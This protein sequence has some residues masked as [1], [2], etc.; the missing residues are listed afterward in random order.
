MVWLDGHPFPTLANK[1][2]VADPISATQFKGGAMFDVSDNLSV[3]ANFGVVEKPPIMDNV[4]Y[5]DGTVA[6]DPANEKF[7]SYE[8]GVN[9]NTGIIGVKANYYNTDWIDRNLTKAVSSGQGSSGDTDVIFLTGVNQNHSGLEVEVS[10]QLMA[11][12]RL[13]ASISI[14]DWKFDGDASGNYQEDL[15]NEEGQV[16]GQTTTTYDYALNGL[17]VGDMPQTAYVLGATL[18]PISGLKAQVLFNMYKNNYSDWSP[19]AREYDST[20]PTDVP[21]RAQVWKAPDYSKMDVHLTYDLPTIGGINL[22]AFAHIFNALDDVYVQDATDQSK[23]NGF[24]IKDTDGND[25]NRHSAE[26]AEVFLGSPR[27]FNAGIS[28]Y[29]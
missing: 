28:V 4:I 7:Q 12:L 27:Y 20:D 10:A 29:F 23:Y 16:I 2:I 9:F 22:Q 13:D 17:S 25:T 3:F 21:D 19:D 11:M 24:T 14:G 1:K 8:A 5:F 26:R 18:T 15:F 6:S